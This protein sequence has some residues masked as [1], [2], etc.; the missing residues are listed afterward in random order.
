MFYRLIERRQIMKTIYLL[1]LCL[2]GAQAYSQAHGFKK[3]EVQKLERLGILI[4][5]YDLTDSEVV[6]DFKTILK[7]ERKR[8]SLKT[9]SFFLLP[10]TGVAA[11]VGVGGI[12]TWLINPMEETSGGIG[13]ISLPI[14]GVGVFSSIIYLKKIRD[15]RDERNELINKYLYNY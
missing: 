8:K 4:Q 5:D 11:I 14:G 6:A 7:L 10:L 13:A 12:T 2:V 1:L 15:L 9:F 3:R